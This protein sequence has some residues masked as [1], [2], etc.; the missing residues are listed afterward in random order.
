MTA[1]TAT[2]R[3]IAVMYSASPTGP[4]IVEIGEDMLV[5]RSG[6]PNAGT[7]WASS[8]TVLDGVLTLDLLGSEGGCQPGAV[9][10]Y[11]VSGPPAS[12]TLTLETIDDMCADVWRWQSQNPEGYGG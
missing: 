10:T 12:S 8:W 3:P 6:D 7:A 1:G 11:R 4:A 9:G 5:Q 2:I